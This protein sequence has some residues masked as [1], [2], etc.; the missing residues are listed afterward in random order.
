MWCLHRRLLENNNF[1][2]LFIYIL[3]FSECVT[4]KCLFFFLS[5]KENKTKFS[6]VITSGGKTEWYPRKNTGKCKY[7]RK[8]TLQKNM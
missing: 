5:G 4:M 8:I 2:V 7:S 3:H 6:M 1:S